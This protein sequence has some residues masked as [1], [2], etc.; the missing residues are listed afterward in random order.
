MT[1]ALVAERSGSGRKYGS[2]PEGSSV[3]AKTIERCCKRGLRENSALNTKEH[4]G[5]YTVRNKNYS[6]LCTIE[7]NYIVLLELCLL[8]YLKSD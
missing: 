6:E 5:L 8:A 1:Y 2:S 4:S 3:V 7:V